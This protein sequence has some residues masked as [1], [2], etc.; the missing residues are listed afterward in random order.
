M[1]L[2]GWRNRFLIQR[3]L[4]EVFGHCYYIDAILVLNWLK[5]WYRGMR[6][7]MGYWIKEPRSVPLRHNQAMKRLILPQPNN[8]AFNSATTERMILN[9]ATKLFI[10]WHPPFPQ[11]K[12]KAL[13]SYMKPCHNLWCSCLV[14]L[15]VVHNINDPVNFCFPCFL[16]IITQWWSRE[17]SKHFSKEDKTRKKGVKPQF[18]RLSP[19]RKNSWRNF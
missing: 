4:L 14:I 11:T 1:W 5:S 3:N 16:R 9:L 15:L 12:T 19:T 13:F 2:S 7:N 10:L 18:W 8:A 17:Q 6:C